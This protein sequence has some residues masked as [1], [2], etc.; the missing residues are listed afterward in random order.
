L[1]PSLNDEAELRNLKLSATDKTNLRLKMHVGL[2][3]AF[4]APPDVRM[5]KARIVK[6]EQDLSAKYAML[7]SGADRRQEGTPSTVTD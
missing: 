6:D 4:A 3:D 1:Q 2:V 5:T 7:W